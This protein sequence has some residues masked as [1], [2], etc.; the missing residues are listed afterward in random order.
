M[1]NEISAL[2][3]NT[4]HTQS[5]RVYPECCFH[6]MREKWGSKANNNQPIHTLANILNIAFIEWEETRARRKHLFQSSIIYAVNL[7]DISLIYR[8]SDL[9]WHIGLKYR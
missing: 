2:Q 5:F 8:L 4:T 3:P 9:G 7:G 6:S 1:K